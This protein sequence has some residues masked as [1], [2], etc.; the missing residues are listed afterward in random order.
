[1]GD[2]YS[3]DEV[4]WDWLGCES[5]CSVSILSKGA[6][7]CSVPK[8]ICMTIIYFIFNFFTLKYISKSHLILQPNSKYIQVPLIKLECH[9]KV[10]LFQ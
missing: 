8:M 5:G 3:G 1:M 4:R 7:Y 2:Q 10:H 6:I 9:G